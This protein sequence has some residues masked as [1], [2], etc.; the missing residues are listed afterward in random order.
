MYQSKDVTQYIHC[1]GM[2]VSQLIELYRNIVTFTQRG[3]EKLNDTTTIYFQH[4]SNHREHQ[5]LKQILEKRNC[6]EELELTGHKRTT[7]NL[8]CSVCGQIGHNKRTCSD[9]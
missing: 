6:I 8:K 2:H 9:K 1:F 4:S 7:R 5:A 3:L